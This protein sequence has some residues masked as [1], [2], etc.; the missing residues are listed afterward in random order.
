MLASE[1]LLRKKASSHS[2][3]HPWVLKRYHAADS[4]T[5][6]EEAKNELHMTWQKRIAPIHKVVITKYRCK[7]IEIDHA[8]LYWNR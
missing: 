1:Q 7:L 8:S 6:P 3:I 4:V 5:D 2:V